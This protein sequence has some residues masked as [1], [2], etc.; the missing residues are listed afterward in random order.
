VTRIRVH[1]ETRT[2]LNPW[3]RSGKGRDRVGLGPHLPL[4]GPLVGCLQEAAQVCP[5]RGA[6]LLCLQDQSVVGEQEGLGEGSG[7]CPELG[8][9]CLSRHLL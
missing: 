6:V 2:R 3:L 7:S 4:L 5:D 8:P 9:P 1:C